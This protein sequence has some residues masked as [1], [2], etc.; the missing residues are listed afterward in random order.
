MALGLIGAGALAAGAAGAVR[1][2]G[3]MYQAAQMFTQEDEE[4]LR[5]LERRKALHQLGMSSAEE[6]LL[7]HKTL[8]PIA[9]SEREGREQLLNQMQIQDVG[10]AQAVKAAAALEE[11]STKARAQAAQIMASQ[12]QAAVERDLEEIARLR[13]QQKGRKAGMAGALI[14]AAETGAQIFQSTLAASQQA[15]N[16]EAMKQALQAQQIART[17]S[18]AYMSD[19]ATQQLNELLGLSEARYSDADKEVSE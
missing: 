3:G 4:R 19:A 13:A 18:A 8:S 9:A 12:E 16:R 1:T 5:E 10:S 7:R 14:G 2:G 6:A 17:Q 11:A 15:A